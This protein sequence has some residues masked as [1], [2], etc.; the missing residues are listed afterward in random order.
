VHEHKLAASHSGSDRFT[1]GFETSDDGDKELA[2]SAGLNR[3][4]RFQLLA[5]SGGRST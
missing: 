5:P 1:E 3:K 4:L 2:G